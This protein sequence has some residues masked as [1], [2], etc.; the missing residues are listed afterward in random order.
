VNS[1]AAVVL[2]RL[3]EEAVTR[4]FEPERF[5]DWMIWLHPEQERIAKADYDKPAVLT[6]VSGSG[7]TC[8][9]VHRARHLATK[10]PGQRIGIL[11]L[12]RSL[13]RLIQNLVNDL[14]SRDER[15]TIVVMAFYDYFS[16]LVEHFGPQEYLKQLGE[17]AKDHRHSSHIRR[18]ID[19]ADPTRFAREFDPLSGET[20]QDTWELFAD[21]PHT[22]TNIGYFS[23]H[24][25]TYQ[26]SIDP[27]RYLQEEFSLIRSAVSVLSRDKD[28][29]EM[30]RAGRAIPFPKQTREISLDLLLLFEE[31][32]LS[33]GVLDELSLTQALL[34]SRPKLRELPESKRFRCLLVD[35][36]QD[37]STLDL[38]LLRLIPTRPKTASF[39]LVIPCNV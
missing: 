39:L 25:F 23:D 28:Y 13:S 29:L 9:V 7:K 30:E 36:Y 27:E 11:T 32:M 12:N 38:S 4:I 10:Y 31:A 8:I 37:F 5:Q 2:S 24:L 17:S 15:R 19:Q 1:D 3:S 21:Q 22:R 26:T 20:L 14:C 34:P 18:A 16:S 6:G 35:E 33:G